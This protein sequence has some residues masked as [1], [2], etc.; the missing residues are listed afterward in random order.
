M[1]ESA[2]RNFSLR[3]LWRTT[4]VRLTA[5]FIAIFVGFA[6]VL[7][8]LIAYQTSI[9]IQREQFR[10]V[11]R[12]I[13][14]IRL[15]ASRSGVRTLAFAV[16][17]LADR[18]GPGIYYL[19]D[20]TGMMIAGNVTEF[21][22][23]VLAETGRFELQ[24]ER[25]REIYGG[26]EDEVQTHG[27]A[28]VESM[29]LS[30]GLRLVVGRDVGE[31][32]GFNAI[33]LRTFFAGAV[34]II[35]LSILAGGFTVRYVLRRIDGITGTSS[36]IMSGSL[37]ERVPVTGRNDEF[38]AVATSL[39]A[40]LERIEK[41][42]I[43]LKEV[44]DNVAHDLKTPLTRLRNRAEAALRDN[45]DP[46][47]QRAALETTIAESDQL[48]RTFNA[49]LLIAR[50]EAGTSTGS[51]SDIDLSEVVADVAE[52]YTPVVEDAG[53]ELETAVEPGLKLHANRELIGQALVNLVENAIKY[54]H[55]EEREGGRIIV[56]ARSE[57][58]RIII[59][60]ADNGPGIPDADRA[61][62]FE[63]FARLEASRTEPGAGLGLAL[64]S[65]VVRLHG[66]DIVFEDNAPGARAV[67]TFPVR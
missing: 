25:G 16:Q 38:D 50:A 12:E 57:A 18:P 61:R 55:I 63:R 23:A 9:Q 62:V 46:E 52:L 22:P 21:P 42:M 60:V 53:M 5:M 4:T 41:L 35:L 65:A 40:M 49:L 11:E 10:E 56:S 26:P 32:R 31:R 43:G 13:T 3:N 45:A 27:T 1:T 2:P 67:I 8:A 7:L 34:G 24:Y 66:G 37:S 51:F 47:T 6:I 48:I 64:V 36:K 28:V 30:N 58:G 54:G 44:T 17:R 19:G 39:N 33:I 14:Q 20:P 29:E 59:E 15:L